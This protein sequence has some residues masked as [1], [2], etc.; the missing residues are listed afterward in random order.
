MMMMPLLLQRTLWFWMALLALRLPGHES[1]R[2]QFRHRTSPGYAAV[3]SIV[4]VPVHTPDVSVQHWL[5]P[6]AW[7]V[8]TD[9]PRLLVL[10]F[11]TM[12]T[13][14]DSLSLDSVD[15]HQHQPEHYWPS[16]HVTRRKTRTKS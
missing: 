7:V 9:A 1:P 12:M 10:L 16:N 6:A 13:T 2:V 3:V 11:E 8:S 15:Q 5:D 4:A 14:K